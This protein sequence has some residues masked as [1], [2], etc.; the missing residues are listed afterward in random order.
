M[1]AFDRL[2]DIIKTLRSEKGCAW[3]KAQTLKS[4]DHLF[5][6]ECY[7]LSEAIETNHKKDLQEELGDVFFMI[8]LM[9]HIAEQENICLLDDVL[10]D[11]S[12]KL[13]YRH[14]HIFGDLELSSQEEIIANWE[15]L[16]KSE[17]KERNSI[18]D[19]I[20]LNLP[21]AMRFVKIMRKLNNSHENLSE[22]KSDSNSE[23]SQLQ[24]LLIDYAQKGIDISK[25]I[26]QINKKIEQQAK[27]KGL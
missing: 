26:K 21:E 6:E 10:N 9:S 14:P 24:N 27:D 7:E 16:K 8:L 11:A 17:K 12:D 1:K 5:L 23:E 3:D 22:Y 20:P 19:G 13:I 4:L 18:F 2:L 25:M 15:K